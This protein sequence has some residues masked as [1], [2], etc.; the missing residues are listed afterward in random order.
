MKVSRK[1]LIATKGKLTELALRQQMPHTT[2]HHIEELNRFIV[3]S[4]TAK[5]QTAHRA[6]KEGKAK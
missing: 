2:L 3:R 1:T 6:E 5:H 4:L